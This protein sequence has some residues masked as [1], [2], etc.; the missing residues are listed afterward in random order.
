[1][2]A[3]ESR[4]TRLSPLLSAGRRIRPVLVPLSLLL[5]TGRPPVPLLVLPDRRTGRVVLLLW[6][7]G[8]CQWLLLLLLHKQLLHGD[9][10]ERGG[11]LLL[12]TRCVSDELRRRHAACDSRR[13]WLGRRARG[14]EG[15]NG[16]RD[17]T[18]PRVSD[19]AATAA[20]P[21]AMLSLLLLVMLL[22]VVERLIG[23]HRPVDWPLHGLRTRAH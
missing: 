14:G 10:A 1:M 21:L 20:V 8:W 16:T 5:V 11:L 15:Q 7:W 6:L 4:R 17:R 2:I 18:S 12:W 13:L 19:P 3:L 23:L 22:V 9:P